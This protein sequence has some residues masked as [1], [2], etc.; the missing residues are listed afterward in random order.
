MGREAKAKSKARKDYMVKY[1]S[2]PLWVR[3]ILRLIWWFRKDTNHAKIER[4]ER[5]DGVV[6]EFRKQ[7]VI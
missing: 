4:I 2:A 6:Q 1:S 5:P 3:T 7:G